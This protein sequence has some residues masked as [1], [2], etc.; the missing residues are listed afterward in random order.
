MLSCQFLKFNTLGLDFLR[1]LVSVLYFM[2]VSFRLSRY[3]NCSATGAALDT[4]QCKGPGMTEPCSGR[5]DCLECGTCVCYN[6]DQF[7]GPYCQYD[8]T[9]CQRFGGFLCNGTIVFWLSFYD[10]T[11][12]CCLQPRAVMHFILPSDRG[13]CIMGRCSCTEGWQ[14]NACE[15]PMSNQTCL[16]NKKVSGA[17]LNLQTYKSLNTI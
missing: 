3:C 12:T 7:E 5:G 10:W 2:L 17:L 14:G 15:C 1:L 8:K 13:S 6:P 16:D 4:S 9:Q 11:R